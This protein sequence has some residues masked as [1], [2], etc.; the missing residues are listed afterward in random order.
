MTDDSTGGLG[1]ELERFVRPL[2]RAVESERYRRELFRSIGTTLDEGPEEEFLDACSTIIDDLDALLTYLETPPET[3]EDYTDAIERLGSFVSA[4]GTLVDV[5]EGSDAPVSE[6]IIEDIGSAL[7]TH[8]VLLYLEGSHPVLTQMGVLLAVIRPPVAGTERRRIGPD[9]EIVSRYTESPAEIVPGRIPDLFSDP[10]GT[11]REEYFGTD[12]PIGVNEANDAIDTLGPRLVNLFIQLGADVYYS[13]E[14]VDHGVPSSDLGHQLGW[15]RLTVH[16]SA[17]GPDFD[18]RVL[19]FA[20]ERGDLKILLE[21]YGEVGLAEQIGSWTLEVDVAASI[22]LI[23]FDADGVILPDDGGSGNVSVEALGTFTGAEETRMGS[24]GHGTAESEPADGD[25]NALVV[26]GRSSTRL[27]LGELTFE[28]ETEISPD[29]LKFETLVKAEESA[30]V[31]SAGDGDGFLTEVF[32]NERIRADFDLGL[33]WSNDRGIYV[34]GASTLEA[35]LTAGI[36]IGQ[37]LSID[38]IE[39]AITPTSG[40]EGETA[41][42]QTTLGTT[43]TVEL[44]PVVG[45]VENVGLAATIAFPEERDGNL[46]PVDLDFGFKPPEGIGISID[47]GGLSGGG[48]LEFD[49]ENDRYAG[50]LQLQFSDITINAAGLVTT[51]LPGGRDGYSFL[52]IISGEFTPIQLGMGFTLEGIGGLLGVHRTMKRRPLQS[53][54]REGNLDSVLFPENPVKHAQR[55]ISDLRAIF[56]PKEDH[57]VF[58]PM[59]RLGWGSPTLVTADLGIVLEIETWEVAVLGRISTGLPTPEAPLVELNMDTLGYLSPPDKLAMVEAHLYDSR[60]VAFDI[61]GSMAALITWGDDPRFVLSVGGFHPQYDPPSELS[62]LDRL[63]ISLA[64]SENFKLEISGYFAITSNTVQL[65]ARADLYAG[66]KKFGI[67]GWLGFD[68]LIQFDPFKFIA[69]FEAGIEIIPI[70]I[71]LEIEGHISGPGPWYVSG[72]IKVTLVFFSIDVSFDV[73]IGEEKDREELPPAHVLPELLEALERPGNWDGQ[74]TRDDTSVVTIREMDVEGDVLVHPL[75]TLRVRQ[76]VVPLEYTIDKF[77]NHSPAKF[78]QFRIRDNTIMV[79]GSGVT[80]DEPAREHFAP[81]DYRKRSDAENLKGDDFESLLAGRA[82]GTEPAYYTK[83]SSLRRRADL[84]YETSVVDTEADNFIMDLAELG[85]HARL[86]RQEALGGIAPGVLDGRI[87]IGHVVNSDAWRVGP[88]AVRAAEDLI[89]PDVDGPV[90]AGPEGSDELQGTLSVTEETYTVTDTH[91]L[92]EEP[93]EDAAVGDAG[94]THSE[95]THAMEQRL[96]ARE[97]TMGDLQV[98]RSFE[99]RDGMEASG[100]RDE[101]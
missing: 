55:I 18:L 28:G 41:R 100:G 75:G 42:I 90:A 47:A 29:E 25:E 61:S 33:G 98:S 50:T 66:I 26:G 48:Y 39:V 49:P 27:E 73:T 99:A 70:K 52:I 80:L 5:F 7:V 36:S 83:D 44:G 31:L 79:A 71:S 56:P 97:G 76:T 40:G 85:E 64:D 91:T 93:V 8:L 68:S 9:T 43:A 74:R 96:D 82:A 78:T 15:F 38:T 6:A 51:S 12:G 86:P 14:P 81:E 60:V 101:L 16:E 54:V 2:E 34:E 95:A 94:L 89:E 24:N 10:G 88:K 30:F 13:G 69:D 62:P 58:G 63:T 21:P 32:P 3:L 87:R 4:V 45:T 19:T 22:D 35:T 20:T 1:A 57:Y 23:G 67:R 84:K 77:G 65:G 59:L 53:A 72:T 46:G 37:V 11:L 17:E 92:S